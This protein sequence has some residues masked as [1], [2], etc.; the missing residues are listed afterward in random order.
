M[1]EGACLEN[2]CTFAR[3]GGSNPFLT[4]ERNAADRLMRSAVFGFRRQPSLLGWRW[5]PKT[6]GWTGPTGC[7]PCS[8]GPRGERAGMPAK[9]ESRVENG[10]NLSGSKKPFCA[11]KRGQPHTSNPGLPRFSPREAD[12]VPDRFQ[13]FV[14]NSSTGIRLPCMAEGVLLSAGYPTLIIATSS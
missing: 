9:P 12:N 14:T 13:I 3:T 11:Q 1:V 10:A 6:A 8:A 5:K 7:I 4:A 2:R